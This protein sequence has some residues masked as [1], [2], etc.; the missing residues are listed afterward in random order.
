[1][2]RNWEYTLIKPPG[3]IRLKTRSM[4]IKKCKKR[5]KNECFYSINKAKQVVKTELNSAL[6][7]SHNIGWLSRR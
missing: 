3:R 4:T 2:T 5:V 7:Y 6:N 1:M